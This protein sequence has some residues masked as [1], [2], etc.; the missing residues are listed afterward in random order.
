M[1]TA[2]S[3]SFAHGSRKYDGN[4]WYFKTSM[5]QW[6]Y[7]KYPPTDGTISINRDG[8]AFFRGDVTVAKS[9]PAFASLFEENQW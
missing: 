9:D 4:R 8:G 1:Y 6:I 7:T 3:F 5:D 2:E